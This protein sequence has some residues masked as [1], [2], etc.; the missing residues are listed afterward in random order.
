MVE[1]WRSELLARVPGVVHGV[2][3]RGGGVSGPP[4]A[5]L[6]LGLHVGDREESVRHNRR[7]ALTALGLEPGRAVCAEQ[8]HGADVAVVTQADAGRGAYEYA[9]AVRGVDALITRA[10]HTPLLGCF[11]D[12]LPILI[13]HR[14]GDIVA[15]AHAGWKGTLA[16]IARNVV[17]RLRALG[18]PPEDLVVALG[19]GIR[20]CCYE[21]GDDLAER[22]LAAFGQA[23]VG[24]AR[25]GRPSLDLVAANRALLA[26]AGVPVDR[27]DLSPECTACRTDRYFSHR[28][29]GGTTGRI[30]AVIAIVRGRPSVG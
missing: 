12:C 13:A 5:S 2:T 9:G 16:G 22:F 6:N 3:R 29:E 19:P 23:V 7:L 18:A 21:V 17:G 4:Y 8:V 10:A 27:I 25:S 14:S 1:F 15:L 20:P 28:A 11:A 26:E 24:R 30:G